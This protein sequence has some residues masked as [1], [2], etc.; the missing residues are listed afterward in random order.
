MVHV[1][2]IVTLGHLLPF[3]RDDVEAHGPLRG[4][5]VC[6]S[7]PVELISVVRE[8]VLYSAGQLICASHAGLILL[9]LTKSRGCLFKELE[10]FG[11]SP[12]PAAREAV[13]D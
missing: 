1:V 11:R 12:R 10:D 9:P 7:M 13:G 5:H 3:V 6:I 8:P 2:F 4:L